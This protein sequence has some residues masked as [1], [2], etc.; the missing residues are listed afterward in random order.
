MR[1]EVT[2]LLARGKSWEE[3]ATAFGWDAAKLRSVAWRDPHFEDELARARHEEA[4]EIEAAVL[5]RLHQFAESRDPEQA[6][7][8]VNLLTKHITAKRRDETRLAV[9]RFRAQR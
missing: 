1:A 2:Y 4:R 8:A 5:T 3:A 7:W 6:T 9:E